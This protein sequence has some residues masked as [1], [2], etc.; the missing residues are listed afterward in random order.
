VF[1]T[2]TGQPLSQSSILRRQLHALLEAL[3]VPVF[4]FH[5]FHRFRIAHLRKQRAPE[6]LV[7]FWLG[8]AG[9]SI[10]DGYDRVREDVPYRKETSSLV[11]TGFSVPS[12]VIQKSVESSKDVAVEGGHEA[13]ATV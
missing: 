10:T 9:K 3:G 12:V 5:A 8:H 6:G 7:Q 1:A 13:V 4:G 2:R 11:G